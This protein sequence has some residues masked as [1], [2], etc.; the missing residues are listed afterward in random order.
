MPLRGKAIQ[1]EQSPRANSWTE[2][3]CKLLLFYRDQGHTFAGIAGCMEVSRETIAGI[4]W[5][6]GE[7][8][9]KK[10]PRNT[11]PKKR[12]PK[13]KP[14]PLSM[15]QAMKKALQEPPPPPPPPPPTVKFMDLE[16]DS[17]RCPTE[18]R[19]ENGIWTFCPNKKLN[20]HAY[21]APHCRLAY[22]IGGVRRG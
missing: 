19:D 3:R 21:C 12:G 4:M 7:T 8:T 5:R 22:T 11:V 16:S 14:R 18:E 6:L 1:H 2:D 15:F 17:C 9:T 20:G 13:P 10:P